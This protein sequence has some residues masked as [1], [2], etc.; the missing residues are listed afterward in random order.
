MLA[1]GQVTRDYSNPAFL[2][3]MAVLAASATVGAHEAVRRPGLGLAAR[4]PR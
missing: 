2:A 4:R 1:F 3:A